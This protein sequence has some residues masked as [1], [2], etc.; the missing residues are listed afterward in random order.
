MSGRL[1]LF[2]ALAGSA[3]LGCLLALVPGEPTRLTF[4]SVGQGDCAVFQTG[5]HTILIDAGPA[6]KLSDAGK[7]I[8]VPD[9][10]RMGIDSIDL[11]LLSHPDIDHIGG[12]AAILKSMRVGK[13]GLPATF[14]HYEPLLQHLRED[15]CTGPEILWLGPAQKAR[16]GDFSIEVDCPP[17][18]EGEPDN[19]GSEFVRIT[20]DGSSAVFT[21]DADA[22]TEY[23]MLPGHD[24][25]AQVLKL[26]HH[27]SRTASS[28]DWL[29]AVHP[30]WG[31]VSCGRNNTYG[32][33]HKSVLERVSGLGIKVARTDRDGNVVFDLG[34][35][36]WER[37]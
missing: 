5:G 35:K 16:V 26:G 3:L 12:L 4:L 20:G 33:P 13:I 19:D 21:G 22:R 15:G 29:R 1:R 9:L 27:G 6:S 8:V 17:W 28:E 37:R 18:H 24:W 34:P 14:Q 30:A 36:G 2:A 10:R 31:I 25:S 32:H 7:K 11:V 23:R